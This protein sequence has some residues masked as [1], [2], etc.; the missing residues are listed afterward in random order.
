M[1]EPE[2]GPS[3]G[4]DEVH[5]YPAPWYG[6]R[7]DDQVVAGPP[8]QGERLMYCCGVSGQVGEASSGSHGGSWLVVEQK[9]GS[10]YPLQW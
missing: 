7:A 9:V 3:L 6:E 5:P 8:G 10:H 4:Q 1:K 2:L